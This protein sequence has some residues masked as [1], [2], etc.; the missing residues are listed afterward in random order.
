[1]N[2]CTMESEMGAHG[3]PVRSPVKEGICLIVE[4]RIYFCKVVSPALVWYKITLSNH[5]WK[6]SVNTLM[7]ACT[8]GHHEEDK[9]LLTLYI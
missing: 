1:M 8:F 5:F 4:F 9:W 6:A 2:S 7:I 3:K